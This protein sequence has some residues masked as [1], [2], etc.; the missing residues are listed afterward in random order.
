MPTAI[1]RQVALVLPSVDG[2]D[3]DLG[4]YRG[5]PMVV[6]FSTTGSLEAQ[7]DVEQLR[8]VRAGRRD[9]ALVEVALDPT[10]P[11]LI[12]I[13]ADA[14]GIDWPVLLPTPGLIG[15]DSPFGPIRVT[16]TTYVVDRAGRIIWGR[17]GGL[18]RGALAGVVD[19]LE[20]Q[21]TAP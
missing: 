17:E 20:P 11:K 5:R 12:R 9:L 8:K 7:L 4:S 21:P 19:G 18:P 3:I 1:G 15:G 2:D 14:S 10:K 16:P 13:W 6:H